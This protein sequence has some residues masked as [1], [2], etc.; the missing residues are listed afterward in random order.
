MRQNKKRFS[1]CFQSLNFHTYKFL[2]FLAF[3][4]LSA[5]PGTMCS[6][7]TVV[8]ALLIDNKT[9]NC[10]CAFTVVCFTNATISSKCLLL[11]GERVRDRYGE[12]MI[13]LYRESRKFFLLVI[14][15][16]LLVEYRHDTRSN[17]IY[18]PLC[19]VLFVVTTS[20]KLNS[21]N[22]YILPSTRIELIDFI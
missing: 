7:Q 3:T 5:I 6:F 20:V 4:C 22:V 2:F 16:L 17:L 19:D 12:M 13:S 9:P 8:Y 10:V 1:L 21:S 14:S 15:K 11:T 18:H